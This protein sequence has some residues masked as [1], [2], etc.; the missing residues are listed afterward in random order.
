MCGFAGLLDVHGSSSGDAHS[1]VVDMISHLRHRG[2]DGEG[3][4]Q[5]DGLVLGHRRLSIQDLSEAGAQPMLSASGRFV[6]SLNGEIYNHAELRTRLASEGLTCKWRGHSDTETLLEALAH[7]GPEKTLSLAMG[8]FAF[9]LWDRESRTLF[10]AR[11]I[12]GEKPLYWGWAGGSI[13]FGS[14][15]KALR[16]HQSF[17]RK[18]CNGALA[19]YL[20]FGYVPAPRSIH[21]GIYKLEPGCLLQCG[22]GVPSI[23][24]AAPMRPGDAYGS[25]FIRRFYNVAKTIEIQ[26]HQT[27]ATDG[28]ALETVG[29]SLRRAVAGQMIADVPLG[30]FL[31]GGIDSSLVVALMQVQ[32]ARRVQTFTV[33][34]RDN[35]RDES[36]HARKVAHHLGTEHS[37][38]FV[39]EQEARDIIPDLPEIY[40]EPFADSSQIP[41]YLICRAARGSVAVALTGDGGD[42]VFGG[43]NRYLWAPRI[44]KTLGWMPPHTRK[45]L[46]TFIT[47]VP[48]AAWDAVG[49][50]MPAALATVD[51]G[52]KAH[53]FG[54]RI[55]QFRSMDDLYRSLVSEWSA[56][57]LIRHKSAEPPS[58]LDDPLPVHASSDPVAMMMAQDLRTY[59]P[60]D[61][62]CKV[63]RASM[64]VGLET[65]APYLD[66]NVLECSA[67][68]QPQMRI[69]AGKGKWILRKLLAEHIPSDLFE[70][71]KAGFSV[72]LGEWLRGP[73][74][75]WA[76]DL[77][78]SSHSS[79]NGLI[80]VTMVNRIW[81]E[82][83]SGRRD[84]SRRLWIMLMLMAW[85]ERQR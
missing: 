39:S 7:W 79:V 52:E 44:W 67:R 48:S 46:G 45:A 51:I 69:R 30:A 63:D 47:T 4:W 32:S 34:F 65:R 29:T 83:L 61:I 12:A 66:R 54:R 62:L 41:T 76:E 49:K 71:P 36:V 57:E 81:I 60:D 53:K 20:R 16:R 23:P 21:P 24:P 15:L 56:S 31:S 28:E 80:D 13:I 9:S 58:L 50:L 84:W 14:E 82:H 37:T 22:P 5:E 75:S 77:L 26:S 43:Y 18:I 2:P 19:Q 64:A 10:L 3:I 72:P 1:F 55:G 11:D 73:L 17:P 42:E 27:F 8:M 85:Q 70:R 74:K 59:L 38:L 78:F 6:I 35:V 68:L 25:I 33:G 40:D